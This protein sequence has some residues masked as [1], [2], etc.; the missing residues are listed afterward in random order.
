MTVSVKSEKKEIPA[1]EGGKP[2][3]DEFLI[4]GSPLI[5]EEEIREVVDTMKSGWLSTGPKTRQFEE[6]FK[7]YVG[8]PYAV[9]LNSCTAGLHLCL[10]ANG[11][12]PGD[13]VIVSPMTF[14]ATVN[15]IEHVGAKPVF[16]DIGDEDFNID[17]Q[18]IEPAIT[19]KTQ[20]IIPVHFA[21]LPCRM[22]DILQIAKKHR[23]IV[24]EDAAHAVG[25][26]YGG[27][28][29]GSVSDFTCFSFYATKN[30]TTAEGGMVTTSNWEAAEKMR[31][32][33][34]HGM[35]LGA[36]Q[37]Y[38]KRGKRHYEIRMPGY[39]YNMTDL[40]ASI[41]IHQLKKLEE[42][43]RIRQEYAAFYQDHLGE[44]E[45]LILPPD[46]TEAVRHS[47][48]LYP[49]R[50]RLE[51]L[52]TDRDD[53]VLAIQEENIGTGIHYRA[54][55]LHPYYRNKYG[56]REGDF[57]NAETASNSVFSVPLQPKMTTQDL[58]DVVRAL[59]RVIRWY[60]KRNG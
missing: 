22:N 27:R 38:E 45:E 13:E 10:L 59:K 14:A 20:A 37:R 39:K 54:V 48:H 57:P 24:I 42:F 52:K 8:S 31:V 30:L 35:D 28:K 29:I 21:G 15:V 7:N 1:I 19:G 6:A 44:I 41:G 17:P 49:L 40:V 36:W 4:L 18:K 47:W 43:I 53:I 46:G 50:L 32:M 34:L 23:L 2:V 51:R 25:S 26:E 60:R 9:A 58:E 5:G 56:W 16:V 55:H 12:G 33:S 3:R 11:I